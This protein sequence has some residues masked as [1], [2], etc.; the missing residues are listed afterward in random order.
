MIGIFRRKKKRDAASLEKAASRTAAGQRSSHSPAVP[1]EVLR[2]VKL[3]ELRTR[4]LVNSL[5]TGEYRSVFKGQGMEFAEVREYQPGDEVRSIDWNVTARMQRPYVKR[6][7]EERELTVMLAVDVSG[8]ERFGTRRRFKSEVASELAAVLAM[9]AIRNN[10]RV[11]GLMFT[12]R[13]EHVVPPRK[14]RRHALRLIRDILAFEP[15]GRG[16]DIGGATEYLNKML[17]HKAI[18]F[19]VSDFLGANIERP[20]KLLAQRHDLVAVTVED[21]SERALP[22][23]G[24]VRLM[25]PE[26]GETLDVDTSNPVVRKAFD[27]RVADEAEKRRHLLRRLAVDEIPVTTDK[28]IMEPL[29]RFFRQRETRIRM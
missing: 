21:P 23:I 24:L 11:G 4:G 5:F 1:P 7:I 16:T 10:D 14:G 13:V 20:L 27:S 2:Q 6:Y 15:K 19:L 28:G 25:D 8:S 17:S 3:L 9:C 29:L 26:T 22:N 18:I 12:D